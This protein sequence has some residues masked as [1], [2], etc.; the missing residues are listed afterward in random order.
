MVNSL[1][2]QLA[3]IVEEGRRESEGLLERIES[4][5]GLGLQNI[6]LVIPIKDTQ[7]PQLS[8]ADKQD[9]DLNI[10]ELNRL[11]YGD[12]LLAMAALLT[13]DDITPSSRSKFLAK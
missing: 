12:N 10:A 9:D 1:L 5:Q 2:G 11:I 13:G 3:K 7:S 8:F 4:N 6:E